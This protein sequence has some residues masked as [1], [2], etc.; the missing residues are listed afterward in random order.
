MDE[1]PIS[2][3]CPEEQKT[4]LHLG[5]NGDCQDNLAAHVFLISNLPSNLSA[6]LSNP[7]TI[8]SDYAQAGFGL[9]V[10]NRQ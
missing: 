10:E 8:G 2:T 7:F 9:T 3:S 6:N 1:Y 4:A 5:G